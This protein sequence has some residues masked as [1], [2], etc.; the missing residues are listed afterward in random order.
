M[1]FTLCVLALA[2][3]I[4]FCFACS[5]FLP[6]CY[7][8]FTWCLLFVRSTCCTRCH[9]I[10]L[11]TW[12]FLGFDFILSCCFFL[13]SPTV[14]GVIVIVIVVYL[15]F[16]WFLLGVYS[17]WWYVAL[18]YLMCI[19]FLLGFYLVFTWFLLGFYLVCVWCLLVFYLAFTDFAFD[20][21]NICF[22]WF[23]HILGPLALVCNLCLFG[24]IGVYLVVTW[25][26]LVF[27]MVL[28]SNQ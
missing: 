7:M 3:V 20:V 15:V 6:G 18:M 9:C 1:I 25:L 22:T 17:S 8:V 21:D 27:Y 12:L 28:V 10:W 16:T 19:W 2:Y 4:I 13:L 5:W 23:L 14:R 26:L 11:F 24:E